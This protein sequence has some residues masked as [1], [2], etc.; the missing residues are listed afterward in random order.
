MPARN[1]DVPNYVTESAYP[2]MIPGRTDVGDA[3]SRRMLAIL[4]LKANKTVWADASAFAGNE[5]PMKP[6]DAPVPRILN[7]GMPEWSDDGS[8]AVITVRSQDYKDRWFVSV[9]LATGKAK[10]LDNAHDDAWLREGSVAGTGAAAAE[11]SA[12][13]A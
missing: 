11:V 8:Q 6:G 12:A 9:D 5:R 3:Q 13:G 7:W 4:D 2:E 1:Q 10:V